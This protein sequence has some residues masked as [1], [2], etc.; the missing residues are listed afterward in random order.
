[1]SVWHHCMCPSVPSR[2]TF[3]WGPAR[4]ALGSSN[5]RGNLA[6]GAP[7]SSRGPSLG[8][9]LACWSRRPTWLLRCCMVGGVGCRGTQLWGFKSV[10]GLAH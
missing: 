2:T 5:L 4:G 9:V 1:V 7:V 3:L 8:Q 6:L 10:G